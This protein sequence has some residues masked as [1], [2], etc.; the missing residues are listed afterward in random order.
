MSL[1]QRLLTVSALGVTLAHADI[2]SSLLMNL[3][4]SSTNVLSQSLEV[5]EFARKKPFV[6]TLY[7]GSYVDANGDGEFTLGEVNSFSP[8][9]QRTVFKDDCTLEI[10]IPEQFVWGTKCAPY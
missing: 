7:L 2:S 8:Y 4:S 1:V 9:W 6:D 3:P 10:F 5:K